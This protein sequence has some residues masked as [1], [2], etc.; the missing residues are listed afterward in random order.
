MLTYTGHSGSFNGDGRLDLL[1]RN[2]ETSELLVYPNSGTLNGLDTYGEPV[3][4]A[5]G[6]RSD[7]YV[8]VG[9]G[10]FTGNGKADIFALTA[11]EQAYICLNENGLQGLDTLTE[12]IHVGGR[13]PEVAYDTIALADIDGDGITDILGR[14]IDTSKIDIIPSGG[15]V[16]GTDSFAA[17]TRLATI[18]ATDIP[19]GAADITGSGAVDLLVLHDNGELALYRPPAE[20]FDADG[21]PLGDASYVTISHG[22]DAMD[23]ISVTDINGDGRPDLLGLR[24]DGTLLAYVHTGTFDP[25]NPTAVF[26][27][28]VVVAKGWHDVDAIS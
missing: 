11:E 25:A 28:P 3:T 22:W 18:G 13:L 19:I 8:W 7:H 2:A 6:F 4:I 10:D 26:R 9:A 17:P 21:E 20:G 24:S 5:T 14:Q 16:D 15:D 27:A 23:I 1:V 12:P